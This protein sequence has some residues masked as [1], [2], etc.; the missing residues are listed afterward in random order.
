MQSSQGSMRFN[1]DR[2]VMHWGAS[3][4]NYMIP[5]TTLWSPRS[6]SIHLLYSW[7]YCVQDALG[8]GNEERVGRPRFIFLEPG[9]RE[10]IQRSHSQPARTYIRGVS[11]SLHSHFWRQSCVCLPLLHIWRSPAW[12]WITLSAL[13]VR[14][15]MTK[16]GTQRPYQ[17]WQG[18]PRQTWRG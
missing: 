1:R 18:K 16:R 9:E 4:H 15:S 17:V 11:T 13:C 8:L 6:K 10:A 5:Y 14:L 12:Q 2:L 3:S 7:L